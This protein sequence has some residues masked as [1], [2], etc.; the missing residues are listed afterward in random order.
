M[1]LKTHITKSG[2][3]FEWKETPELLKALELYWS[4]VKT[5]TI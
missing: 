5:N 3:T 1:K 4:L 2:T